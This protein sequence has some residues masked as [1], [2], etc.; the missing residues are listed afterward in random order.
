MYVK[1]LV[2]STWATSSRQAISRASASSA[3]FEGCVV[4]V[5]AD[6][7]DADRAGVE[8]QRVRADHVAIDPAEPSLEDLAVS[9][10]EKVVADVVPAVSLHVVEL[11][12]L[13]DRRSVR[14]AC[15]RCAPAV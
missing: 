6:Q 5:G 15:S 10:D 9:V 11:D 4:P 7:R 2:G 13:D 3:A 1:K 14:T 8:A 12:P